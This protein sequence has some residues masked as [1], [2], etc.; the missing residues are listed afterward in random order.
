M[1]QNNFNL[2]Y[3]YYNKYIYNTIFTKEGKEMF[4][5]ENGITLVALVVT[6]IILLILAG[7]TLAIAVNDGGLIDTSKNAVK[8]H[9]EAAANETADL[10][11][12]AD[13]LQDLI[14]DLKKE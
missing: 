8:T 1:V 7:V 9:S 13:Q 5:K 11:N 4:K 14:N 12:M 3:I 6:I 2:G 10:G